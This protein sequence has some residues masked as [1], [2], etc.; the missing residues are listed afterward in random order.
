MIRYI[1]P[2]TEGWQTHAY[3][4]PA[5]R[6]T[7][8]DDLWQIIQDILLQY[9]QGKVPFKTSLRQLLDWMTVSSDR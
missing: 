4:S 5:V 6:K 7:G 2:A 9:I 8:L 1:R 3:L